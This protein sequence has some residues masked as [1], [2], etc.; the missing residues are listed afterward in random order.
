MK[1][2]IILASAITLV[3]LLAF[4]TIETKT[5]GVDNENS[6]ISWFAEKVT[7]EHNGFVDL[8]EGKL[9]VKNDKVVGGSF[10]I[11]MTAITCDD[12]EDPGYNAKLI[13]HF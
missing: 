3:A 13:G 12:I 11:D 6:K 1:R 7:G 4:T 2:N 9:Y 10:T 5:Y 8:N